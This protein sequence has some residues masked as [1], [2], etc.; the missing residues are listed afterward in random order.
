MRVINGNGYYWRMLRAVDYSDRILSFHT[1]INVLA[2]GKL[3]VKETITVYNGNGERSED[4]EYSNY[5]EPNDDIQRGIVRDIPTRYTGKDGLW[6]TKPFELN[7]VYN[8]GKPSN[9]R[10][11]NLENG[12]RIL[13]GDEDTYLKSGIYKYDFEYE[14]GRQL[15]YHENKDELYWNVNGN[16]WVFYADSVSCTIH[17]PKG[18][19][20]LEHAC[21]TGYQGSTASDCRAQLINHSTIHFANSVRIEPYQGLTVAAAIAKGVITPEPPRTIVDTLKD[22]IGL[23]LLAGILAFM[24]FFYSLAWYFRG[25]D[26][27]KGTIYPQ[28]EPPADISPADAGYILQQDY[29]S[30]L[31]A[32]ALIDMAVKKHLKIEVSTKRFIFKT[33]TYAFEKP[34]VPYSNDGRHLIGIYGFRPSDLYGMEVQT[35]THNASIKSL[36]D[37][38]KTK[39]EER[40]KI[41]RGFQN[42]WHGIF[43][44]NNGFTK[45]GGVLSVI[46]FFLCIMY[47]V[48]NFTFPLIIWAVMLTIAIIVTQAVFVR[49][50][51]AYTVKGR[52]IADHLE[53]FKMYLKTAEQRLF[54][55]L[56][57]PEKTLELF[58]KYLP[59]AIALQVENEWAEK[60]DSILQHAIAEGYKP[61]YYSSSDISFSSSFSSSSFSR[62]ISSGLSSSISSASTPPSSSG[63]GSSGGGSSGG[64]G[65]GGGGGGW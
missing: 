59:Y 3:V 54:D 41:K 18:S 21:Y 27:K 44:K 46:A 39:L 47:L 9:Y 36:F 11:E 7:G 56:T 26:P 48:P 52:Q 28:L 2:N 30:H 8:N 49:L 58:E 53:G 55:Y 17:F 38:L 31:F 60:F 62:G 37:A 20:I 40:F 14:T 13:V 4:I 51:S 35:G 5:P 1:N 22:N 57:P 43:V 33:T 24:L 61:S 65:G 12:V 15:I 10:A 19:N 63:G 16:G 42:T 50:M 25:R 45:T 34:S 32:A 29:A 64:G 23:G 6:Q